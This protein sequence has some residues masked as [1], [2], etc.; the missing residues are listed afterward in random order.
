[1]EEI[2]YSDRKTGCLPRNGNMN[3]Y[4]LGDTH[5]PRGE[6]E[7]F[8]ETI[9]KIQRD[10]CGFMVFMGDAVEGITH[11][12]PRYSPEET[13]DYL[14]RYNGRMMNMV[15]EQY[16]LWEEDIG[17]LADTG[18]IHGIFGG[19]HESS[20]IRYQAVNE[21]RR[22]CA[23]HGVKYL[24][25]GYAI[26]VYNF[27]RIGR[28]LIVLGSH[29]VGGGTTSGYVLSRLEE[30]ARKVRGADIVVR[31]HH[32]KLITSSHIPGLDIVPGGGVE[33]SGQWLG[34]TGSFLSN[35]KMGVSDY[36][37]RKQFHPLPIGYLVAE[38]RGGVVSR[39]Y[40]VQ[41]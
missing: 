40:E 13:A 28:Q 14:S 24:G 29:G 39:F 25:D 12:D 6:R 35:Y 34:C 19:N 10:K 23:R 3:L 32:H 27:G 17:G 11:H 21:L 16:A 38:I 30:D 2:I 8:L 37:E 5:Y 41:V 20:Q 22:I 4:F 18:R 9:E 36:G 33:A 26:I 31:G 7:T 1:M 15:S